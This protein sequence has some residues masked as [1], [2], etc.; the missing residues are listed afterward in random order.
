MAGIPLPT[1][2]AIPPFE[3]DTGPTYTQI[4]NDTIGDLGSDADAFPSLFA[5]LTALSSAFGV[6][7]AADQGI[8]PIATLGGA[9]GILDPAPLDGTI[10]NYVA[11]GATGDAIL[12]TAGAIQEPLLLTLP[13]TPGD[14]STAFRPPIQNTHDFGTVHLG[15]ATQSLF[16]GKETDTNTGQILGILPKGYVIV[17]PGIFGETSSETDTLDGTVHIDWTLTMSPAALGTFTAQYEYVNESSR[18][19]VILTLTVNVIP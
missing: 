19:L 12:Q 2:G 5:Q 3:P 8:G 4:F 18:Q 15:T 10:G 6:E 9:P 16:L 17:A 14:G 11:A 13:I 1:P 7:L